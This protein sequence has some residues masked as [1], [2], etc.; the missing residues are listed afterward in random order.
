[1]IKNITKVFLDV[2]KEIVL[3]TLLKDFVVIK[4]F[5]FTKIDII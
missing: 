1:M 4:I 2:E 3:L 5:H